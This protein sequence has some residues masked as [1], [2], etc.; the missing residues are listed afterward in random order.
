MSANVCSSP[1]ENNV[2]WKCDTRYVMM[3]DK[4]DTWM[5]KR[6]H[7]STNVSS[8]QQ[9]GCVKSNKQ[10]ANKIYIKSN[11]LK[12]VRIL[13]QTNK[14]TNAV[15][16]T[17]VCC[18]FDHLWERYWEFTYFDQTLMFNNVH[19]SFGWPKQ[20]AVDGFFCHSNF[21]FDWCFEFGLPKK[22]KK[23]NDHG[24][25]FAVFQLLFFITILFCLYI[26][27][28]ARA[29][30]RHLFLQSKLRLSFGKHLSKQCDLLKTCP[31]R[32]EKKLHVYKYI[33][34]MSF[35]DKTISTGTHRRD[36][37]EKTVY[38]PCST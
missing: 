3:C 10:S 27:A 4:L 12:C 14:Q 36:I 21:Y 34:A 29:W 24:P 28:C 19:H 16:L 38:S 1:L 20:N 18:P 13:H 35:T 2:E 26:A 23:N 11:A 30:P 22:Q 32:R 7:L 5:V 15:L 37:H 31:K 25:I 33:T 6:T 8:K 17:L 9:V